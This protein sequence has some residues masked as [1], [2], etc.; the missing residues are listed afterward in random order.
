MKPALLFILLASFFACAQESASFQ[1]E[2][3]PR[4]IGDIEFDPKMDNS[5]FKLCI[6]EY[7]AHYMSSDLSGNSAIDYKG[8]KYQIEKTFREKYHSK[9]AKKES[10]YIRIRFVVNCEGKTDRFR[11]FQADENYLE[12][13]F[14]KSITD[15]I[16][17][18][19]K[20]LNGW[21]VKKY[22]EQPLDYYQYL[23]FKIKGGQIVKI[24]P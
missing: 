4:H 8:E 11:I 21:N 19:S 14:D 23:I 16:I 9:I 18:I 1:N 5:D 20:S 24:L 6:P 17:N 10:G 3:P 22:K 15:Q 13:E 7:I 12:T 2:Y